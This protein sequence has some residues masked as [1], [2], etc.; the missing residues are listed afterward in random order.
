MLLSTLK[1]IVAKKKEQNI[2]DFVINNFL[3]EYLQYPVLA[4]IYSHKKYKNLI[5]IGGSCLRVCYN[6]PRL[7]EDLDF[8]YFKKDFA[9]IDLEIFANDL[10]KYFKNN[11]LIDVNIK[12]QASI[13]IYLKFPILKNLG[14]ASNISE[15][16]F[17]YV[18]IEISKS[19]FVKPETNLIPISKFG[20]NFIAKNYTLEYLMTGKINAILNRVWFKGSSNEIN[21]KGRDFYDLYWYLQNKISPNWAELEK[22]AGIKTQAEFV[23]VIKEKIEKN[24]S[25]KKLA[26]DLKNF[27]ENQE[28]VNNFCENYKNIV[29]KNLEA[30]FNQK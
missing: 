27:F 2:P 10:K 15:S 14:L 28:F 17:L 12:T 20:Y 30:A 11:Y 26:Y 22:T 5:F 21:V 24:V 25:A 9:K 3:K 4:Y 16:D 19:N 29:Y 7:S 1:E 13:R 23:K 18:K 6:L 8:D